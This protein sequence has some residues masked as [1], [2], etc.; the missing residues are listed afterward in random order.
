M[1]DRRLIVF[2]SRLRQGVEKVYNEHAGRIFA[3]AETMKGYV[4]AKDF[5]A[6]DGERVAL[7]E[8][9][10]P[11]ELAAWRAQAEHVTAQNAGRDSYYAS[12]DL[13]VCAELRVSKFDA[14]TGKVERTG[15]DPALL[16]AIGEKWL[17]CFGRRDMEGL[18]AL[19]AEHATPTS[20]P[21]AQSPP[22]GKTRLPAR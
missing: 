20:P 15:Q 6:D 3:L 14:S 9:D 8:W 7:I 22:E 21:V 2:R 13:R 17:D 4:S 12:Y 18:L 5:A 19:Y 11:A 1:S 16:R 10:S